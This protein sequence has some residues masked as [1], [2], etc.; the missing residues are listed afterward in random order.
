[1]RPEGHGNLF[2]SGLLRRFPSRNDRL[3][4]PSQHSPAFLL[5]LQDKLPQNPGP[6][7]RQF[8]GKE[9]NFTGEHL[10]ARGYAVSTVI[11]ELGH[12]CQYIRAQRG[13]GW[14][15]G[16]GPK[17]RELRRPNSSSPPLCG[18]CLISLAGKGR[19]CGMSFPLISH[20]VQS[21]RLPIF[22]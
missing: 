4:I 11:F 16:P 15:K 9:R 5:F 13:S 6:G 12:V 20:E 17:I 22:P 14:I 18:G 2:C 19:G 10:W 7:F 8:C 1:L 3:F 21:T